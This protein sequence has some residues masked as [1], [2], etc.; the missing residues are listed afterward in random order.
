MSAHSFYLGPAYP[1]VQISR[2]SDLVAAAES[3]TLAE[4]QWVELKATI[5]A[6]TSAAN[7]EVARDLASLSVDGGLL[8]VGVRTRV[9]TAST[10]LARRMIWRG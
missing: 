5:P 9:R 10:S 1:S 4:T 2:W 8:V 6:S 3:G 7:L